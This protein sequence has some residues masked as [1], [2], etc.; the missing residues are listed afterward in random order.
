[1]KAGILPSLSDASGKLSIPATFD[2]FMDIAA[3]HSNDMR[4]G[5]ADMAKKQLYWLTAKTKIVFHE[6]PRLAESVVVR[7]WPEKPEA[8]RCN[9]SYE[10]LRDG[11]R[12]VSGR[13]EWVVWNTESRRVS[14]AAGIFPEELDF[15]TPAVFN[16]PYAR[17]PDSFA[18]SPF[19]EYTVRSTDIDVGKHMNN[20][21]YVRA[22]AGSFSCAEWESFR[23]SSMDVV[24]QTPCFEGDL[25]RIWRQDEEGAVR[26]RFT[27]ED[28]TVFL[29]EIR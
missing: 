20:V 17:I 12:I 25:I 14:R 11:K 7:T 19:A 10:I 15:V 13:T 18:G 22:L 28:R 27:K 24:F 23:P 9:R 1:M 16:E 26:F 3:A 8:V 29:A 21:A 6:R 2:L 5:F 4:M